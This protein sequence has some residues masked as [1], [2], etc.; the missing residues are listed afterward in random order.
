MCVYN[1]T[2]LLHYLDGVL[3]SNP[4]SITGEL[5]VNAETVKI[6]RSYTNLNAYYFNGSIDDV[7]IFNKALN[8]E[9]IQSIYDYQ[10]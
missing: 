5:S 6:G 8:Q 1:G 2:N 7:M 4:A 9:E 10:K 3:Q